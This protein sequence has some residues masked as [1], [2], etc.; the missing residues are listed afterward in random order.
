MIELP[1]LPFAD[2]ALEPFISEETIQYHYYKHHATYV[3]KLNELIKG[4]KYDELSLSSI[5]RD[6]D[7]AVFNNA[8][9]VFNHTF[10]WNS[11]TNESKTPSE[12]LLAKI[13]DDFGSLESLKEEFIKAGTTLFGSG[14]VWLVREAGG[15]LS[16]K[17]TQ[18]ADTPLS[19]N[20][21]PLLVCD[22]WEHAYYID[23][24]NVRPKY[25]EE[26]W[27][28]INWD[29]VSETYDKTDNDVFIGTEVCNDIHDPFCDILQ[30]KVFY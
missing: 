23:Y 8:A 22:V 19:S 14:W 17:Q 6:S 12:K 28:Y 20:L 21:V 5:I 11:L 3:N 15:K 9:Q 25:L 10:Y 18:N 7:G 2:N 30:S 24:R 4:T 27:A 1:K 26:F 16:L 13:E 29:F